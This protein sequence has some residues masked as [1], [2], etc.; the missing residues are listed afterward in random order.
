MTGLAE[1]AIGPQAGSI[2][3]RMRRRRFRWFERLTALLPRPLRI[4]DVGGRNEFWER[5]DW[6]GRRDVRI[7]LVNIVDQP[8]RHENIEPRVGDATD[9]SVFADDSF[10]IAFSNSVIEH[11]ENRP[12]QIAMA[13]EMRRVARAFWVQTPNF[14]FPIEPHFLFPAWQ[15]MPRMLRAELLH[16]LPVGGQPRCPD[17][18]RAMQRVAAIRLLSRRQLQAMFPG[19]AIVPERFG[20]VVKSWI[21][22]DGFPTPAGGSLPAEADTQPAFGK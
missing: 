19:A 4:I 20:G 16:R 5:H 22:H 9:L 12:R 6:A 3:S 8:R 11:L 13:R 1:L 18:R 15:W 2:S 21:V 10:D 7:T 17:R 14:W